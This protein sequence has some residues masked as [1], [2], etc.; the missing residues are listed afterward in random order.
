MPGIA[1]IHNA[2]MY[3]GVVAAPCEDVSSRL[4]PPYDVVS[5]ELRDRLLGADPTNSAAIDVPRLPIDHAGHDSAYVRARQTFDSWM[6]K[7]V[8]RQLDHPVFGLM[9][10]TF[11]DRGYVVRRHAIMADLP[12]VA[13]GRGDGLYGHE[14]TDSGPRG[15]RLALLASLR[16]QT[17]PVFG[18]YRDDEGAVEEVIRTRLIHS[19]PRLVGVSPDGTL[20]ELWLIEDQE[21]INRLISA[22]GSRDVIIADGHHRYASQFAYLQSLGTHAPAAARS[23]MMA[24]V[25]QE[26]AGMAIRAVHHVFGGMEAYSI[27]AIQD[28]LGELFRFEEVSGGAAELE[29]HVARAWFERSIPVGLF[30]FVQQRSFVMSAIAVDPLAATAPEAPEAWRRAAPVVCQRFI[31]DR[32]LR[33]RCNGGCEPARRAVFDLAEMADSGALPDGA[34]LG[35]VLLPVR[36]ADVLVIAS[37]GYLLPSDS[38]FFWPKM[39]TGLLF[40]SLE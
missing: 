18:I 15:D 37:S 16:V 19:E 38:T 39:P 29:E 6:Q 40:K 33:D 1:P 20:S 34:Q 7:R 5:R 3:D 26:D 13:L 10:Q 25:A 9:R 17:S 14:Q 21:W 24:L 2:V 12:L 28:E 11:K 35:L 32:C 36:L 30:D 4:V 27:E 31:V 23:C 22:F 8:I